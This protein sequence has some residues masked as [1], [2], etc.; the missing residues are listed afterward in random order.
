MSG[1]SV[2]WN[3]SSETLWRLRD[4]HCGRAAGTL[5]CGTATGL[6]H[7]HTGTFAL[8]AAV[9]RLNTGRVRVMLKVSSYRVRPSLRRRRYACIAKPLARVWLAVAPVKAALRYLPDE[10][11]LAGQKPMWLGSIPCL[12]QLDISLWMDHWSHKQPFLAHRPFWKRCH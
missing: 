8:T 12:H 1:H 4:S 6:T 11:L 2:L 9:L 7:S 10:T 5:L 3:I